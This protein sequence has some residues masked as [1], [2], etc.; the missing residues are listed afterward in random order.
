M[1]IARFQMAFF[2]DSSTSVDFDGLSYFVRNALKKITGK[3]ISNNPM[4]GVLPADAPAEIPR[5]QLNSTDNKLR[6]QSSLQRF[7]F[8]IERSETEKDVSAQVF[9]QVFDEVIEIHKKL[10]KEIVR[11]GLIALKTEEDDAPTESIVMKYLNAKALGDGNLIDDVNLAFNRKFEYE[12]QSF[13]CHLSIMTGT[14]LIRQRNLLV[15]QIDINSFEGV[16]FYEK[17]T[18][19]VIK[20]AFFNTIESIN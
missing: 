16:L 13:N 19:E 2:Y 6:V 8:F 1:N 11:V 5:L 14:D 3:E 18:P 15:K 12:G 9:S 7:D 4:L 10:N 20:N 17:H